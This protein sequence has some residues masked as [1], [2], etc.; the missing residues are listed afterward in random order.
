[1]VLTHIPYTRLGNPDDIGRPAAFLLSEDADYISGQASAVDGGFD[2]PGP[3]YN[4]LPKPT[5]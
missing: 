3:L 5:L 2:T 1:M 4:N